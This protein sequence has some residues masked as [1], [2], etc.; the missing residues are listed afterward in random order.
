MAPDDI[1]EL[2]EAVTDLR[3]G[4]ADMLTELRSLV[5]MLRERCEVR[6]VNIVTLTS[7]VK[8]LEDKYGLLKIEQVRQGVYI[9][10]GSGLF[11]SAATLTVSWI[12]GAI[13]AY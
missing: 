10:L 4:Q 3:K 12:L 7:R 8:E 6:A 2:W 13:K 11:S 1:N 9:A 5:A